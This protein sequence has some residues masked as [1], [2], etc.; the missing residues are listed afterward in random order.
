MNR[1]ILSV[2]PSSNLSANELDVSQFTKYPPP[3]CASLF[4]GVPA[5]TK[6]LG[7]ITFKELIEGQE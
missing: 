4:A 6:L 3:L 7:Q 2:K 1:E 5:P